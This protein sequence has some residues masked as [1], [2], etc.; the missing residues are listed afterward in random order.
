MWVDGSF[1]VALP[2]G[3]VVGITVVWVTDV[4]GGTEEGEGVEDTH[5][6]HFGA[7]TRV[8]VSFWNKTS[9]LI[10][11]SADRV[12]KPFQLEESGWQKMILRALSEE[13][14][15]NRWDRC[16]LWTSIEESTK[17]WSRSLKGKGE[18]KG[19]GRIDRRPS[20]T[21]W[22]AGDVVGRGRRICAW[23]ICR[24]SATYTQ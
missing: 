22:G 12:S 5:S 4:V 19:H 9:V 20:G 3:S 23:E 24:L 11:T 21:T 1:V 18:G 2:V 7:S 10:N 15:Q 6:Q 13:E 8:S 16:F 17:W 14:D